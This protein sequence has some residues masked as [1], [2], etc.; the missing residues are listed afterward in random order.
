MYRVRLSPKGDDADLTHP[1]DGVRHKI[2]AAMYEI[3][4][5][6]SDFSGVIRLRR[7]RVVI[8]EYNPRTGL[9]ALRV[10][11]DSDDWPLIWSIK[12]GEIVHNLRS[13]LDQL[14]CQLAKLRKA[15]Y[16]CDDTAFPIHRY[17]PRSKRKRGRWT[18]SRV[19]GHL[20]KRHV[21]KIR[22]LQPYHRKNGGSLSA[23][24]FLNQINNADKH[25]LLQ[26][27]AATPGGLVVSNTGT[28]M[29]AH[30]AWGVRLRN[31]AKV[32]EVALVPDA[33][34][35]R[36]YRVIP[37]LTFAEGCDAVRGLPVI[38]TLERIADEVRSIADS[39]VHEF[40]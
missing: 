40:D 9:N 35:D 36:A 25:R 10:A 7:Y 37:Q 16:R 34:L 17:G 19:R 22:A 29:G 20:Q 13:A 23:L 1:L 14:I 18:D 5:L 31:G 30:L 3:R 8:A 2:A 6:D 27:V 24:W 33:E 26:V 4:S 12:V 11:I 28:M 39:F 21:A 32:V 38:L 15:S